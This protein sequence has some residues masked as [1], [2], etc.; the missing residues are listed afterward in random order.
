MLRKRGVKFVNLAKWSQK[1]TEHMS[2]GGQMLYREYESLLNGLKTE[3]YLVEFFT[4]PAGFGC[5]M[6]GDRTILLLGGRVIDSL[7]L[8]HL[9]TISFVMQGAIVTIP[10]A[11][12]S[13]A[14][15][16]VWTPDI[17]GFQDF[18]GGTTIPVAGI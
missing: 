4:G 14:H 17:L 6:H 9:V 5:P 15:T 13:I 11:Q 10:A 1:I 8:L 3:D 16:A 2:A 7:I 18:R 12:H